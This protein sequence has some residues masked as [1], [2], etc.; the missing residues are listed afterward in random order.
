M[1]IHNVLW[2][3]TSEGNG[4]RISD[5][6]D[7]A[8]LYFL[9]LTSLGVPSHGLDCCG[10]KDKHRELITEICPLIVL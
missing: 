9:Q 4:E 6:Q 10:G 2:V 8:F 3:L 7:Y 1:W 5:P